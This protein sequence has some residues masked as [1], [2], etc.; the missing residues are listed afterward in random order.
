ML[1]EILFVN[2]E[3]CGCITRVKSSKNVVWQ[4]VYINLVQSN[5]KY[6]LAM[7]VTHSR[8]F[9]D[10]NIDSLSVV[11][12][13]IQWFVWIYFSLL[14]LLK[15]V[16]T[17][18][19]LDDY[20]IV[21]LH[22]NISFVYFGLDCFPDIMML[23]K[24]NQNKK[25]ILKGLEKTWLTKALSRKVTTSWTCHRVTLAAIQKGCMEEGITFSKWLSE[26]TILSI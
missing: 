16:I 21:M 23:S 17:G 4:N 22:K 26:E 13:F 5:F 3:I 1:L 18:N 15:G 2:G 12:T 19:V 24:F 25:N 9:N 14:Q 11:F 8:S 10:L 20:C 6:I 7:K